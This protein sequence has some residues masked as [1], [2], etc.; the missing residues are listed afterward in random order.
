MGA[1]F[2]G[3]SEIGFPIV[4]ISISLVAVLIPLLLMGGII[5]RLFREF[6]VPLATRIFAAMI[7][8]LHR[9]PMVASRF[10][11]AHGEERHARFYQWSARC[12]D[13]MLRAY[14]RGL[15]VAM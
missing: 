6:G 7:V 3:A 13:A 4:S 10:L 9:P 8:S 5:G 15:D 12:F 14:E 2:K 1:A 11:R